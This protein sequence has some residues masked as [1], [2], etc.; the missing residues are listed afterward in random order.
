[1][2][3]SKK[4]NKLRVEMTALSPGRFHICCSPN[5]KQL[6]FY[7]TKRE[8]RYDAFSHFIWVFLLIHSGKEGGSHHL[9]RH[10]LSSGAH[11]TLK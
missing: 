8:G 5:S 3:Q 11:K 7:G 2:E 1:M 6:R 4:N 10:S 9:N